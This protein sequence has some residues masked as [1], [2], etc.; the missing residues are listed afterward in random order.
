MRKFYAW[1]TPLGHGVEY[2]WAA[3]RAR[4]HGVSGAVHKSFIDE[5]DAVAWSRNIVPNRVSTATTP[6]PASGGGPAPASA[7]H[8]APALDLYCDGSWQPHDGRVGWGAYLGD[9]TRLCG[10]AP[11]AEVRRALGTP[12]AKGSSALAELLA[13]LAALA[14]VRDD[15]PRPVRVLSDNLGVREWLTGAQARRKPAVVAVCRAIDVQI[16]AFMRA[17]M[18]VAFMH[19]PG[20]AG[21]D[22]NEAADR[23]AAGADAR[24]ALVPLSSLPLCKQT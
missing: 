1:R 2:T 10:A 23:L 7:A 8:R 14:W 20:H 4:V 5:K 13:V 3:C 24:G 6:T 11:L 15:G 19:V 17:G 9:G 22:G 21:I 18:T 16:D 12:D